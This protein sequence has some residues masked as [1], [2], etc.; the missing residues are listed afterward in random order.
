[1]S[2]LLIHAESQKELRGP[3]TLVL[4]PLQSQSLHKGGRTAIEP[5]LFKLFTLDKVSS[6]KEILFSSTLEGTQAN[7][8]HP[9]SN[10]ILLP[11]IQGSHEKSAR[12]ADVNGLDQ[13]IVEEDQ[14]LSQYF[15]T[16]LYQSQ[17]QSRDFTTKKAH[18]RVSGAEWQDIYNVL[19]DP[20]QGP[21]SENGTKFSDL[22]QRLS[23]RL[24]VRASS[25]PKLTS[26]AETIDV[27]PYLEDVDESSEAFVSFRE[28]L[29]VGGESGISVTN[30]SIP[31]RPQEETI[32]DVY[33][34]L[35]SHWL[36]PLPTQVPERVR[37][38][39][40]R[41]ARSV[42]AYLTLASVGYLPADPSNPST[43]LPAPST[44]SQLN[45]TQ[46]LAID[47]HPVW[48][49]LRR[50]VE[51]NGDTAEPSS[52]QHITDILTHLPTDPDVDPSSYDW[53]RT[54]A[55]IRADRAN[56]AKRSDP[57]AR[58]RIEKRAQIMKR[59]AEE[60]KEDAL[61]QQ[62][63]PVI[64]SYERVVPETNR[65]S[66]QVMGPEGNAP[67]ETMAMTQPERGP[68]G[69]RTGGVGQARKDKGKKR[70]AGF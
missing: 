51:I 4:R 7:F 30:M 67:L 38:N 50:Y 44:Q 58:R 23:A 42:A 27:L 9:S 48:T 25:S 16:L 64:G 54:E 57:R 29:A 5:S 35:I 33:Q 49:R 22:L 59:K 45:S 63:P 66:S 17:P 31:H 21:M 10:A 18:E 1:M 20:I 68:F 47:Q 32:L 60:Q 40:E 14:K 70:A 52:S 26:L 11:V 15:P 36:T 65:P 19:A 62:L 28:N 41:L 46:V 56:A 13:F 8:G 24:Q 43:E 61:I 53:R 6:L 3:S 37:V 2:D 69:A 34:T 39:K 12:F 55:D